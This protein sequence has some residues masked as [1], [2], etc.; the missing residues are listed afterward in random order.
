MKTD[1]LIAYNFKNFDGKE[2]TNPVTAT[3]NYISLIIGILTVV[4]VLFFAIQT[5]LAGYSFFNTKGD[6]KLM[7]I[8]REKITY[9]LLGLVIVVI[10]YGL[11]AFVAN[12]LG[13]GNIFD[14]N[15]VVNTLT[16]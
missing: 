13:L 5:I 2:L 4:A 8:A 16:K 12:I 9:N 11:T 14:L 7:Q 3:E 1:N 10:A 15:S 6:P